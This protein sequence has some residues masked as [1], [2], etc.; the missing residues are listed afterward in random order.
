LRGYWLVDDEV[1]LHAHISTAWYVV[2]LRLLDKRQFL[3]VLNRF[4]SHG[5]DAGLKPTDAHYSTKKVILYLAP[6]TLVVSTGGLVVSTIDVTHI[7]DI[8]ASG[9]E[10]HFAAGGQAWQFTLL[11]AVHWADALQIASVDTVM[12]L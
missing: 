5:I 6:H 11:D 9:K 3:D 10:L 4:T 7:S 8:H 1:W 2:R 12:G